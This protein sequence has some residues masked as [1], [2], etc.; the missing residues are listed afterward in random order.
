MKPVKEAQSRFRDR[1]D[2]KFP[3]CAHT[4]RAD[5]LVTGDPDL[6]DMRQVGR[7]RILRAAGIRRGL[8]L[9]DEP[10]SARLTQE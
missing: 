4:G 10:S 7:T 6:L 8:Q 1:N 9:S 3:D 5:Y 2:Q